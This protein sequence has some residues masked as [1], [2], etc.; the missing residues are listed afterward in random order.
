MYISHRGEEYVV[1]IMTGVR[2]SKHASVNKQT[3]VNRAAVI[4]IY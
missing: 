4:T 1:L 3:Q 2:R